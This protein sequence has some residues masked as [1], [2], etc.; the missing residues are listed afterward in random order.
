M[1]ATAVLHHAKLVL[2]SV[3]P[4]LPADA[5]LRRHLFGANRLNETAKRD[6]SRAVFAFFRWREWLTDTPNPEAA[7][8][9][10]L[11]LQK[12]FD[13]NPS[14][15]KAEALE[16][17]AV[18]AWSRA[19]V[20]FPV[21][22]L[23][24][25]QREPQLWLRARIS[26]AGQV[27][28][29]LEGAEYAAQVP[30]GTNTGTCIRFKGKQDLFLT[31]GFHEGWFEIQDLASQAVGHACAA[32]P[33]ETWWDCCA[34]EG[35]KMLHLADLMGNKGLIWASDRSQRRLQNLKRRSARA[36]V[37]NY[38]AAAWEGGEHLPTKT[39]FDG[40]LLDAPCSGV[41]TWQRN[42]HARWTTRPE[43]VA[44]LAEV[45]LR[46]L[47]HASASVKVGGRLV[48]AV[49]TLTRAECEGVVEAFSAQAP[50]FAAAP[51]WA[52]AAAQVK[53]WP[54]E[55]HTNGMYIA[56]WTRTQ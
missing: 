9:L 26:H 34:G 23:R 37:F 49:C 51:V 32:Q 10:A 41:G 4:D 27:V 45:Q 43:D 18:P 38:R 42:P 30:W 3:R 54:H 25:L 5:A 6:V 7:L 28:R 53:L 17:R 1:S 8:E 29:Q 35:G 36:E 50:H 39:R 19:E 46:L 14:S 40:V 44:E 31:E 55:Y 47:R 15:V 56:S 24:E 48:Y 52:G 33:G 22:T 12:R 20:T 13:A 16:A 2:Q 11:T 21:E